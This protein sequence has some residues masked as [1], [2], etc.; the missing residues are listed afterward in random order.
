MLGS[1]VAGKLLTAKNPKKN[2]KE[3]KKTT[4]IAKRNAQTATKSEFLGSP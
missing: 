1:Q 3:R 4:K 2:R